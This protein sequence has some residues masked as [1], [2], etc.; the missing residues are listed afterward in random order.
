MNKGSEWSIFLKSIT[1]KAGGESAPRGTQSILDILKFFNKSTHFLKWHNSTPTKH[2]PWIKIKHNT[3][4]EKEEKN[5]PSCPGSLGYL[6]LCIWFCKYISRVSLW[7][8]ILWFI[9]LASDLGSHY[10]SI[11]II[12]AWFVQIHY[13]PL[14][15]KGTFH[16]IWL[17][18]VPPSP[19]SEWNTSCNLSRQNKRKKN[20]S[21][22][23]KL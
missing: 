19:L 8:C 1:Q 18:I 23:Q 6:N 10:Y 5:P 20:G 13:L 17:I 16:P 12:V 9:L 21:L 4:H 11:Y 15:F 3:L 22:Q 7:S 14:R 2:F